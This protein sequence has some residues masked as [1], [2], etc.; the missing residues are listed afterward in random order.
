MNQV[1]PAARP[2]WTVQ[3]FIDFWANPDFDLPSD[4]L[5]PDVQG[6]WPGCRE[7]LLGIARYAAP[8]RILLRH[9]PDFRL[10]LADHADTG[11]VIFIRWIAHG[12]WRGQ[13]LRMTGVDCIRQR[14]GRVVENRIFCRHPL[15]DTVIAEAGIV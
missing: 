2:R 14:D 13:P 9:V 5:D 7:P 4:E 8:L 10:E 3:Q 6:Y 12:T 1:I 11:E 15:I